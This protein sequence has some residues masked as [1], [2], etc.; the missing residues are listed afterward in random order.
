VAR[1]SHRIRLRC[2]G[3]SNHWLSGK[4]GAFLVHASHGLRKAKGDF[5]PDLT[6]NLSAV[7]AGLGDIY[8]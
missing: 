6:L 7:A 8:G 4:L 3:F 5:E 2:E 1:L